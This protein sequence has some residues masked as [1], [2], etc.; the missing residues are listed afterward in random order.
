MTE[1]FTPHGKY[2]LGRPDS[3]SSMTSAAPTSGSSPCGTSVT[4]DVVRPPST[5]PADGSESVRSTVVTPASG[6][7]STEVSVTSSSVV[8]AVKVSTSSTAV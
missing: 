3:K 8:P 5:R 7:W 6:P 4:V 2:P 1:P